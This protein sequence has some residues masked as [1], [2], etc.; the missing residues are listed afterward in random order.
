MTTGKASGISGDAGGRLPDGKR[1]NFTHGA[2]LWSERMN[3]YELWKQS[4]CHAHSSSLH[5]IQEK[6][7]DA[8]VG[9]S[10]SDHY[11]ETGL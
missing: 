7:P 2:I 10:A 4:R 5:T 9:V 6:Y 3:R 1:V 11:E 8:Y